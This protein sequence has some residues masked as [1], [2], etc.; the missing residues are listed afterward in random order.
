M[1]VSKEFVF[2]AAHNLPNYRGKCERLH[3][4]TYRLLVTV[5]APVDPDT[6]IACDFSQIGD[7]VKSEVVD[8]L[9]HTYLNETIP[10]STAENVAVW[11]WGRVSER[12]SA[13]MVEVKL[14]E[15]PTSSVIYRG[16]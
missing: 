1:L 4:H 15:T 6:G 16:E 12:I 14:W 8:V 7:L 11:I 9:D 5:E 13:Q 10:T 2:D 3:G